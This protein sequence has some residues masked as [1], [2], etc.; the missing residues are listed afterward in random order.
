MSFGRSFSL[1][2]RLA[3]AFVALAVF[4]VGLAT[5]LSHQGVNPRL[6][7]AAEA[8][9]G[10]SASQVVNEAQ[11]LYDRGGG[12]SQSELQTLEHLALANHLQV[13]IV[14]PGGTP[15]VLGDS[16]GVS[17]LPAPDRD[18]IVSQTIVENGRDVATVVVTP[19]GGN[20]LTAEEGE[21][22][23]SLNRL[24]LIAGGI[25]AAAAVV[26][27][28]LLAQTLLRPLQRIRKGA[29]EI[30]AG[31]LSA[32]VAPTGAT[33]LAGVA[34]ALNRLA[35]TLEH[36]EELRRESVANVAHE[37]R[38]PV[39]GVLSRI[40]AAQDGVLEDEDENLAAMHAEAMR[41]KHL[42]D[43][44]SQLAEA[45]RPDLLLRKLPVDLAEIVR[46]SV[47]AIAPQFAEKAIELHL[48]LE[49]TV[50]AGDPVRLGQIVGNLLSNAFRYTEP[51]GFVEVRVR[52]IGDSVRLEVRD[53]GIGIHPDDHGR[54]FERF[55]RAEKSRSRA[56]GG[57]GIGLSIVR[58]LVRAHNGEVEVRSAPGKGSL[59][60]V[61]LPAPVTAAAAKH[62]HGRPLVRLPGGREDG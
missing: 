5:L 58:E 39:S 1:R 8:R 9:L 53:T 33:E 16:A 49:P 14:E 44:L 48:D 11:A 40:E 36:E 26:L 60:R 46:T 59:F 29:D 31:N 62:T 28:L 57:A 38:T 47:D 43:D 35:E 32:R 15:L 55:W 30:A 17:E 10:R 61:T 50:L 51:D 22:E 13:E 45:Q 18:P 27:A 24:H 23:S 7:E 19:R 41:L 3:I 6:Q 54:I 25:A 21:L 52:R 2:V 20:P 34:T 4:A 37:F 12:W 42:L 56:T